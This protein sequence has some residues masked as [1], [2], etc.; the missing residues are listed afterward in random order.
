MKI[1]TNT[2]INL[3]REENKDLPPFGIVLPGPHQN[4]TLRMTNMII[5]GSGRGDPLIRVGR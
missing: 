1:D 2:S 5:T 3:W 4:L